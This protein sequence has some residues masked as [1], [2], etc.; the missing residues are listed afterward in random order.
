MVLTVVALWVQFIRDKGPRISA[1]VIGDT[2][3]VDVHES[4][5][6]LKILFGDEP[7]FEKGLNLKV[8]TLRLANEGSSSILPNHYDP[9]MPWGLKL[10]NGRIVDATVLESND[11][12]LRSQFAKELDASLKDSR[13]DFP[14]AIIDPHK[15]VT[16]KLT[17]LY[18]IAS[19][20][21]LEIVG[22]IAGIDKIIVERATSGVAEVGFWQ[23][24]A[25]GNVFVH[26][27]RVVM[28]FVSAILFGTT[29]AMIFWLFSLPRRLQRRRIVKSYRAFYATDLNKIDEFLLNYYITEGLGSLEHMRDISGERQVSRLLADPAGPRHQLLV[30]SHGK[31]VNSGCVLEMQDIGAFTPDGQ[32]VSPDFAKRFDRLVKF[33][34]THGGATRTQ[35]TPHHCEPS[36]G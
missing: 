12:Y 32:S 14:K 29:L 35:I 5:S 33:V 10:S 25:T 24:V 6:Q 8:L 1:V 4:V 30:T 18:E 2:N 23:S 7:V 26:L 31:L 34:V 16:I 17:V 9:T 11:D 15:F 19:P 22:K 20:T 28:Y 36:S 3:V 21:T 27:F 13:A